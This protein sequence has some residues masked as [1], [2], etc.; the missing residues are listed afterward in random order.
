MHGKPEHQKTDCTV[1]ALIEA[2]A[3]VEGELGVL[4][5]KTL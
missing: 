3:S 5:S 2:R 4:E 1:E